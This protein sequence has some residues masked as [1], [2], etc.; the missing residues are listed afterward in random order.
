MKISH[1]KRI[2]WK[3]FNVEE[4]DPDVYPTPLI[5]RGF[6]VGYPYGWDKNK[7]QFTEND[8]KQNFPSASQWTN[9]IVQSI[10]CLVVEC[11]NKEEVIPTLPNEKKFS[12]DFPL[13]MIELMENNITKADLM[14]KEW[15]NKFVKEP[16]P[17]V[18]AFFSSLEK[19]IEYNITHGE[20]KRE[21]YT[22]KWITDLLRCLGCDSYK[23]R[24]RVNPSEEYSFQIAGKICKAILDVRVDDE[25]LNVMCWFDESKR[26]KPS[27]TPYEHQIKCQKVAE[28]L[29]FANE[30]R[31]VA[32]GRDVEVF[33]ISARHTFISF[34]HTMVPISYLDCI[35]NRGVQDMDDPNCNIV[36]KIHTKKVIDST[37]VSYGY[38]ITNPMDR[39]L[40]VEFLWNIFGYIA[41]EG[42]FRRTFIS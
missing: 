3:D 18:F 32:K 39:K 31:H 28:T 27:H 26:L 35:S 2:I 10:H 6:Y 24:F 23:G 30:L 17:L 29:A 21:T 1:L 7:N 12:Y 4:Y 34:S 13:S 37:N 33:C 14:T 22:D 25:H 19:Q 8:E 38:D 16:N 40:I 42:I 9:A 36:H 20:D 5:K 11:D 15:K 41:T